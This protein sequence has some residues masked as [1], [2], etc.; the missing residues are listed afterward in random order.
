MFVLEKN[1]SG[2][3]NGINIVITLRRKGVAKMSLQFDQH[4][5]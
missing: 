3:A 4:F 2:N 1:S 5:S